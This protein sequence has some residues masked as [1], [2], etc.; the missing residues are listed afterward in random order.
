[1]HP[2]VERFVAECAATVPPHGAV[3]DIGGLDING[4]I[5]NLFPWADPYITLDN[6]PG[7]NVTITAD[8]RTWTPDRE[9][10]VVVCTEVLEHVQ[11]WRLI[12]QTCMYA[13]AP[14]GTLILT[15]ATTNRGPHDSHG[16]PEIPLNQYY[17]NVAMKDFAAW[18]DSSFIEYEL[19]QTVGSDLQFRGVVGSIVGWANNPAIRWRYP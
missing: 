3:L 16:G 19:R 15:C 14:G 5:R 6:T 7:P 11:E 9:Y 4:S 12:V 1:M 10:S 2:A 18:V 8:A 13:L 17:G